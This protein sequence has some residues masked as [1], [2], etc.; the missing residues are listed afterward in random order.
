ME[1]YFLF[2]AVGGILFSGALCALLWLIRSGQL[3]DLD[4]PALRMLADEDGHRSGRDS[5]HSTAMAHS[6][7]AADNPDGA[8]NADDIENVGKSDTGED[9][10]V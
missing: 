1:L 6:G 9:T 8:D 10:I 4:T 7:S 5:V 3:D 2:I